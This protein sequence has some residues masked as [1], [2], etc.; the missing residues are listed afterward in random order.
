MTCPARKIWLALYSRNV[1]IGKVTKNNFLF[2]V[3]GIFVYG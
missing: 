1:Q 2:G 3:G